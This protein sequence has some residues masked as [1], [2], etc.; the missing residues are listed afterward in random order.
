MNKKGVRAKFQSKIVK[1]HLPSYF[2]KLVIE[3]ENKYYDNPDKKNLEYL[4][5]LYKIGI[6]FYSIEDATKVQPLSL[7][8]NRLIKEHDEYRKTVYMEKLFDKIKETFKELKTS[9]KKLK[10]EAED[11]CNK[12]LTEKEVQDK[13][14]YELIKRG[15]D[16]QQKVFNRMMESKKIKSYL[17]RRKCIKSRTILPIVK[18]ELGKSLLHFSGMKETPIKRTPKGSEKEIK[19]INFNSDSKK[20]DIITL[21][22]ADK[23]QDIQ[24]LISYFI[25][26]F[27]SSYNSSICKAYESKILKI[28]DEDYIEKTKMN[29]EYLESINEFVQIA[30]CESENLGAHNV[31]SSLHDEFAKE[32]NSINKKTK[33]KMN[34]YINQE[35]KKNFDDNNNIFSLL[36][37]EFINK[38]ISIIL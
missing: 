2:H 19:K 7:R 31:V 18:L 28:C 16:Y 21:K 20:K 17:L 14:K 5:Y 22:K 12:Y 32:T 27:Y 38:I 8:M 37:N 3:S 29:V 26:H 35:S 23:Y 9:K 24:N 6:E 4:L 30:S 36:I 13:K 1:R 34:E 11:I 15:L 10:T 25:N 33:D